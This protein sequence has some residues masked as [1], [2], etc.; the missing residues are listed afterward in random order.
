[1]GAGGAAGSHARYEPRKARLCPTANQSRRAVLARTAEG[2]C[3]HVSLPGTGL[4]PVPT[5]A[6]PHNRSGVFRPEPV[7]QETAPG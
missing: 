3:P 5:Q 4:R 7:E 2:G 1:M 6:H